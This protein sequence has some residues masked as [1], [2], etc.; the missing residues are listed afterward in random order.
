MNRNQPYRVL[1]GLTGALVLALTL[2]GIV[3]ARAAEPESAPADDKIVIEYIEA[4]IQ[5]VLRSLAARAGVNVI[6]G[7]EVQG[8]VTVHLEDV[9]FLEAM[10]L[11]VESKGYAFVQ[12]KNIIKVKS[13][14]LL[15]AEPVELRLV[16]LNYAKAQDLL[17]TVQ[18]VMSPRGK[19]QVDPRSNT[20]ILADTPSSLAKII[21]L[22]QQLDTQT[23]QV[24][25]EAKFVETTRNPKKDLGINWTDTLLNHGLSATAN[26]V[27]PNTG[28][29]VPGFSLVK[30][31]AGGP[32]TPATALL[33]AGQAR[34]VFSFINR[35]SETELLANPRIVTTDN[36][37]ARISIATQFPIPNFTFSEQTASLQIAGFEYKDIGIIL[38]VTPR[39]NKDD[40]ITL[41]VQPEASSSTENA[42]LQSGGGSAVEIPIINTRTAATTVLIKSGHTLAIGGL[43]RTDVDDRYT[44]VP[45]LGDVPGIG[46]FFRSKSLS[47][48]KRDLLIFLTPTIIAPNAPTGFEAYYD[49]LPKEELYTNDT[50]MPEDNAKPRNFL[51]TEPA[52]RATPVAGRSNV[53]QNFGPKNP[54]Q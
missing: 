8:K 42:T 51:R 35:D 26:N 31:L 28:D 53:K 43:M 40:F 14:E 24:M 36:G 48:S 21:P 1:D 46:A 49:G 13:K 6:L 2:G 7:D 32:W 30:N 27:D 34:V 11:I 50:W 37:K 54:S 12:D 41:E 10:R 17:I 25:I 20:L 4:D 44:K 23:P 39:I 33:N 52:Q 47:K 45:V 16:T 3:G 18:G 9:S 19:A 15:E 29:V 5:N 22:V 38:N